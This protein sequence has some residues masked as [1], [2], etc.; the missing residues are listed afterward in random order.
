M[1]DTKLKGVES[2]LY[3][4]LLMPLKRIKTARGLAPV[5]KNQKNGRYVSIYPETDYG[6]S[7]RN[8]QRERSMIE[9]HMRIV[10]EYSSDAWT[11][12]RYKRHNHSVEL[13]SD[14]FAK[15]GISYVLPTLWRLFEKSSPFGKVTVK[16]MECKQENYT[17]LD[18]EEG[19]SDV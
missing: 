10:A 8:Y 4:S 13:Y 16:T 15:A 11:V 2:Y 14:M 9:G 6:L 3:S 5:I 1:K 12:G 17:Y 19:G 18:Y 7:R